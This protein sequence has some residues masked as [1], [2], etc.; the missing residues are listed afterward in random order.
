L[1]RKHEEKKE[2]LKGIGSVCGRYVLHLYFA[3]RTPKV[4]V[5]VTNLRETCSK[6]LK[7][8][9]GIKLID[10]YKH[11]AWGKSEQIVAT[12]TL[13]KKFP[14]PERRVIGDLSDADRVFSGL[15]LK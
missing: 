5:A 14:L 8:R 6:R 7:G 2:L 11:P 1:G 4:L 3:G 12:P 10:L 9:C 13:V 15:E